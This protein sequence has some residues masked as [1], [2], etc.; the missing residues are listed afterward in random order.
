MESWSGQQVALEL[1]RN[2]GSEYRVKESKIVYGGIIGTIEHNGKFLWFRTCDMRTTGKIQV[3]TLTPGKRTRYNTYGRAN[4]TSHRDFARKVKNLFL[5]GKW[6]RPM[7]E[8]EIGEMDLFYSD[9]KK[10]TGECR[11]P[12]YSDVRV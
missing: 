7:N 9:M 4:W 5:H 12:K 2:F 6:P 11:E 10:A 3:N 8:R 1:I